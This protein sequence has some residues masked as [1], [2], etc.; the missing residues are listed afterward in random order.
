MIDMWNLKCGTVACFM[1]GNETSKGLKTN[2]RVLLFA[3]LTVTYIVMDS[4]SDWLE[5][6]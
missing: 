6:C 5:S 3:L 2:L 1:Y 4:V